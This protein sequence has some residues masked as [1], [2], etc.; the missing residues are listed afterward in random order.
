MKDFALE[1]DFIFLW[2]KPKSSPF[3]DT[4]QPLQHIL[5]PREKAGCVHSAEVLEN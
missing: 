3:K 1:N 2:R 4:Q 5:V